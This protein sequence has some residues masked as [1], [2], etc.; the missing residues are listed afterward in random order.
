MQYHRE[1]NWFLISNIVNIEIDT[2]YNE[3]ESSLRQDYAHNS[4]FA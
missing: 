4:S 1:M 3:V 2:K